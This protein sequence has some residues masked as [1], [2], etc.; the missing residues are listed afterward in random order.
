[1]RFGV[2]EHK[3]HILRQTVNLDRFRPP[4]MRLAAAG[5]LRVC[6][7]GSLD[8]R[9]GFI[10]LLK[11]IRSL[12]AKYIRL[13][14]VGA[15]GDQDCARLFASESASLQIECAPSDALPVYQ[16]SEL[17]VVPTLADGLPFVL[18][19]GMA[20]GLPAVVTREAGAAECIRPGQSGWVVPA[21]QVEAL[22]AAIQEALRH[23]KE[24]WGMGQQARA[25]VERYA[26]SVQLQRL[27]EWF[28][29]QAR[30]EA[31]S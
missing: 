4:A 5:P 24:L 19:E 2:P 15:A 1:M 16:Q 26:G 3:I 9:E 12:G 6:Y 8:L 23:R 25:H 20:C 10:Y 13:R 30:F 18:V 27:S 31:G 22:A 28:H 17:L 7:V 21:G 11:A 29:G 14:V